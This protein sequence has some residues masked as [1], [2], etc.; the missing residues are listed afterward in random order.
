MKNITIK[1]K[2]KTI[3]RNELHFEVQRKT[4][5][6]ITKNGKAYNRQKSKQLA[7]NRDMI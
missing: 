5:A 7:K 3:A 4:R 2:P 1:I 6:S